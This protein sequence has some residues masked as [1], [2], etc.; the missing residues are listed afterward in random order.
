[1]T[2]YSFYAL[3]S[4]GILADLYYT[5]YPEYYSKYKHSP[6]SWPDAGFVHHL[7]AH[8][9]TSILLF[10]VCYMN[11]SLL[12]G[13][14]RNPTWVSIAF[15][16]LSYI[17][18]LSFS[19]TTFAGSGMLLNSLLALLLFSPYFLPHLLRMNLVWLI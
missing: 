19:L 18:D 4:F 9:P 10:N 17:P 3:N 7:H 8:V 14:S 5:L 11:S 1:M 6:T 12:Q 13:T 2:A 16:G 15:P